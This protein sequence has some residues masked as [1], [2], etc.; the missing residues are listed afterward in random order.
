MI[1]S[2]ACDRGAMNA[3]DS[4]STVT[5]E[6]VILQK[7]EDLKAWC[8]ASG[9]NVGRFIPIPGMDDWK[10]E[11]PSCGT[12]WHGGSTVLDDHNRPGFR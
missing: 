12:W 2:G 10:I 11:C 5:I 9:E 4:P 6:A 7:E 3:A 8:P 1:V